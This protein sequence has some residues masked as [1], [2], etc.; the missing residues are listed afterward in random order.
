MSRTASGLLRLSRSVLPRTS[1]FPAS[2]R[3]PRNASSSS[4]SAW[5]M[6]PIA[7]SSTRLRSAAIRRSSVS[8]GDM[9]MLLGIGRATSS[10]LPGGERDRVRGFLW[11][12]IDHI[13]NF[14]QHSLR[15][16]QDVI[17][18]E[19]QHQ[20]AHR[21]QNDR[22][23]CFISCRVLAPIEF[24]DQLCLGTAKI[25]D[26]LVDRHLPFKFQTVEATI[27]HAEPEDA[28]GVRLIAAQSSGKGDFVSHGAL[29]GV[30]A[31]PEP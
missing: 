11:V 18:P 16:L 21:L 1:R 8:A 23:V 20:V 10:P 30:P 25:D 24:D 13:Q 6:V 4:P 5:I 19:P 28:L 22:A 7:P 31:S 14:F 26:I 27:A 17:V 3:A 12:P 15:I 9:A 2:K 29:L